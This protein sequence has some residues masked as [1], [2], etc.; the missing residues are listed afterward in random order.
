MALQKEGVILAAIGANQFIELLG[1]ASKAYGGFI[2]KLKEGDAT[3]G[4]MGGGLLSLGKAA[5][6]AKAGIGALGAT[7]AIGGAAL[8]GLGVGIVSVTKKLAD[9]AKQTAPIQGLQAQFA[10]LTSTMEGGTQGM[11]S[12]LQAA[13]QGMISNRI[14]FQ[15]FNDAAALVS[16]QFAEELPRA[17]GI[18]SK[19][20]AATGEDINFL[21]DS[22]VRGV[23]R[24]QPLI[25]DNLKIQVSAAEA[26]AKATEK[27]L[28]KTEQQM[29]LMELTLAK[30]EEKFGALPDTSQTAA[31][32]M[33]ILDANM[34]NIKDTLGQFLLPAW[35][36]GGNFRGWRAVSSP[37][38]LWCCARHFGRRFCKRG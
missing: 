10:S 35:I 27:Q 9:L 22:Y 8:V 32:Q 21:F 29:A 16:N 6:V 3:S 26:T 31:A 17:L 34:Q 7:V 24:V 11:L 1:K 38:E 25:I 5:G 33:A 13:S 14:L 28:T 30:L 2:N 36:L 15:K 23:G 19:V 18:I 4:K 12:A 20:S 37:G